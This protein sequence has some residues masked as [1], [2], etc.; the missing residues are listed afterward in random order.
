HVISKL[1][2]NTP[3]LNVHCKSGDRDLGIQVLASNQDF[4]WDFDSGFRTLYFC[5]LSWSGKS[6][7]LMFR[8]SI[9]LRVLVPMGCVLGLCIT[10]VYT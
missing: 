2:P 7:T 6:K 3:Y 8:V 5:N 1:P 10:M 4:H 9:G